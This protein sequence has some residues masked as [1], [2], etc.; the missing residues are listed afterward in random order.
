[1]KKLLVVAVLVFAAALFAVCQCRCVR[2]HWETQPCY[3]DASGYQHCP[4]A[5]WI[6]DQEECR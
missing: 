6:C 3:W 4:P 2:G 1:M 5:V